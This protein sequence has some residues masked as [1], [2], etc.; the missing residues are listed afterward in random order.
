[1]NEATRYQGS[2]NN[3]WGSIKAFEGGIV[4]AGKNE[5]TIKWKLFD[6]V[7]EDIFK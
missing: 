1:M 6:C 3:D 7:D 4:E 2:Y 5:D